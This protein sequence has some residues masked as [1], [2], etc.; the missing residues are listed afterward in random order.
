[1]LYRKKDKRVQ[2]LR[3]ERPSGSVTRRSKL[4]NSQIGS[5]ISDSIE[6]VN[7]GRFRIRFVFGIFA[8]VWL[9]LW[10]RAWHLQVMKGSDLAARA[11]SQHTVKV[12]EVGKRGEILDRNGQVLARTV[13][14]YEVNANPKQIKDAAETAN[15][16][17]PILGIDAQNIYKKISNRNAS[18][19]VLAHQVNDKTADAIRRAELPGIE[20]ARSST[21]VY[22]FKSMAG[23]LLGFVGQDNNGLEGLEKK[24]D[25]QLRASK[26]QRLFQRDAKGRRFAVDGGDLPSGN[27]VQLTLDVQV[28][29]FA[30][31]AIAKAVEEF[32]ASWGGVIVVD[33]PSGDILAWA[34]YPFFN[35]ND[36]RNYLP[37]Q[38]RNRL[39]MDA[40]EPGSTFKPFLM[41]AALQEKK[42]SRDTLIDCEGG[43]WTNCGVTI[44]DTSNRAV[45]PAH[46]II[47]YSSNIGMAKIGLMM[48][49]KLSYKYLD[50][51]GFGK[52]TAVPVNQAKGFLRSLKDWNE[53]DL[54]S[55]WFGQSISIT[56]VQLAQAYLTLLNGGEYKP[57]KLVRDMPDSDLDTEHA[58]RVYSPQVCKQVM[59]MM[60]EVVEEDGSGTRA[61]IEGV[62]VGG[63]TGTAQKADKHRHSYGR[64]RLASFVGF[65]PVD[66][67][68]YLIVTL[69]DEPANGQYGGVVAAPVFQKIAVNT[70]IYAGLLTASPEAKNAEVKEKKAK[71]QERSLKIA[72]DQHRFFE[73]MDAHQQ[74]AG[75]LFDGHLAKPST[76]VPNVIGKSV[77]NAVE[78]FARGGIVPIIKGEGR[79]VIRQTPEAG[80][81]WPSKEDGIE[82]ILWLSEK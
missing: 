5:K 51:L 80:A 38:Y 16:L 59:S 10:G 79:R 72:Q 12:T 7:W 77:R 28:Q 53:P 46:K 60:R 19:R 62:Q 3:S 36:F 44:R 61:R 52:T 68:R 47:R 39:A 1:M 49:P 54:M 58:Q 64:K 31:E 30:E 34:Q 69:V 14:A 8:I 71:K 48:G 57:L 17:A 2:N 45:L 20:L 37:G 29:F 50:A 40:L 24:L 33:V 22:P 67:P 78:L 26:T 43:R 6:R 74:V 81:K 9:L 65:L 66:N 13:E 76:L 63:K 11:Q 32:S 4:E 15:V 25:D 18:I 42:I 82:C 75:L 55:T 23:H 70:M 41:A 21:R 27:D 35:P 56:G 73:E